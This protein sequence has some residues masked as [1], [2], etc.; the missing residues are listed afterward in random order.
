LTVIVVSL[1]TQR[2]GRRRVETVG[3]YAG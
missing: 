3:S 1:L 2:S